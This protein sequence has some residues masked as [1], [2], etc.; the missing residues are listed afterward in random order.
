MTT[1]ACI[2]TSWDDG[3]PLDLRV[4]EL[5]ARY[6]LP[7]TFYVPASTRHATMN[8]AQ[9][10]SLS[11]GFEIGA[12]TLRH[13]VLTRA[14]D[15]EAKQQIVLSRQWVEDIT[16]I[17]CRMFCPPEGR[18]FRRHLAMIEAG[19]YIGMRSTELAS[20]DPPRLC[21]RLMLMPTSVQAY[22][23]RHLAITRNA[24]K[25]AR[26]GNLWRYVRLGPR[27][28][29]S[30]LAGSLLRQAVACRGVFHLWGHSWELQET[31][32]W[33]RLDNVLRMLGEVSQQAVLLTNG[34]VC[35]RATESHC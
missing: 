5:L 12:H 33:Q 1:E 28:D 2:T 20:L 22:P 13:V 14:A 16:G 18:Y 10:R 35:L 24:I 29:W 3:H 21:G 9:I 7:G 19:G 25:R 11:R 26:F 6:A 27:V 30:V 23:H 34:Q 31:G 4:A 32:Q 8:A 17:K 15:Q